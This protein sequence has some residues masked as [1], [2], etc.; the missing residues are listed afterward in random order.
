MKKVVKHYKIYA[1]FL[2]VL[3]AA[4]SIPAVKIILAENI[5]IFS[6]CWLILIAI[7]YIFC[8]RVDVNV[9]KV[10]RRLM[11]IYAFSGAIIYI[12]IYFVIGVVLKQLGTSPYDNSFTGI[13]FNVISIF[14]PLIARE[15]IRA[16]CLGLLGRKNK[17]RLLLIVLLTIFMAATEVNITKLLQLKAYKDIF[18]YIANDLMPLLATNSLLTAFVLFGGVRPA[19]IYSAVISLFFRMFPV[20]PEL[21]WIAQ[22]AVGMCFPAVYIFFIKG[23]DSFLDKKGRAGEYKISFVSLL[24]FFIVIMFYWFCIGVFSIY[25]TVILT[26]SMEP[27]VHPGDVVLIKRIKEEAEIESLAVGDVINFKRGDINITHRIIK[28]DKDKAGNLKFITKGDNNKSA[29]VDPVKPDDDNGSIVKVI[30]K[31]GTPVLLLKSSKEVPDNV[32]N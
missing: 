20:I 2:L 7:V 8:P 22:S 24:Q 28:I 13:F 10:E 27:G 18:I 3:L 17:Y 4:I 26:G 12:A 21:P 11:S 32:V 31:I 30:R 6:A 25:P 23:E 9:R 16:Y 5:Y 1:L 19:V 29:D 15:S 14:L